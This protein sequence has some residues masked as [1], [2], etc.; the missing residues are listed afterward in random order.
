VSRS[1]RASTKSGCE[2]LARTVSSL[3]ALMWVATAVMLMLAVTPAA[4]LGKAGRPHRPASAASVTSA[5]RTARHTHHRS[6]RSGSPRASKR[7]GPARPRRELLVPGTGY[8]A[9]HGAPAV[10]VLQR[11]LVTVGLSPGPIDGRY[12]PLT[13]Q[14]VIRFQAAHGLQVDGVAGPRTLAALASAKPILQLGAGYVRGGSVAVRILQRELAAAGYSPGAR[15]GRYGPRTQRAVRR[16]QRAQHLPPDGIAGPQTSR[17][18]RAILARHRSH[19]T[20]PVASAKRTRKSHRHP[21]PAPPAPARTRVTRRRPSGVRHARSSSSSLW[22]ILLACLLVVG[23]AG[24]LARRRPR[25]GRRS[26]AAVP[27]PAAAE[28]TAESAAGGAGDDRKE[29]DDDREAVTPEQGLAPTAARWW[30][31]ALRHAEERGDPAAAFELGLLFV[32]KRYHAATKHV[33]RRGSASG[34][35]RAPA[36]T[37]GGEALL[38]EEEDRAKAEDAFRRADERGHPGAACNLGVLLEHRGDLIGALEAYRRADARGDAI[39]AYNLGALLEQQGDL[40]GAKQAYR[41]ADERGDA[42]SAYSLGVL[43]EADGEVSGAKDA[44]RRADQRGYPA[45]AH[46]PQSDPDDQG[47]AAAASHPDHTARAPENGRAPGPG[48]RA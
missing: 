26:V 19:Q 21:Q 2:H 17:H 11:H 38:V 47:K 22:V 45:G 10:R 14:A 31:Q 40:E 24:V 29:Q 13:Q 44:Y 20:H 8:Q 30:E 4:A 35:R 28:G 42:M 41:R 32:L 3:I 43:L 12:G 16:F 34:E 48:S 37:V 6:H 33:L 36:P 18:L 27:S 39:G 9:P 25:R 15:D 7:A 5:S 1:H 23:L 46:G